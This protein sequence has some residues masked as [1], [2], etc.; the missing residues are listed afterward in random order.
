[1]EQSLPTL[2]L[3][4]LAFAL[5]VWAMQIDRAAAAR[6]E[7]RGCGEGR[8]G[9]ARANRG[10]RT[11]LKQQSTKYGISGL[12]T[13]ILFE[14]AS[15][16]SLASGFDAKKL[17]RSSETRLK[18]LQAPCGPRNPRECPFSSVIAVRSRTVFELIDGLKSLISNSHHVS[19]FGERHGGDWCAKALVLQRSRR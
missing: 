10:L 13:L 1:M 14:K 16:R 17:S 9:K 6:P 8:Q 2:T 19:C 12:P 18:L 3:T 11:W 15:L 4:V 5:Q 7:C